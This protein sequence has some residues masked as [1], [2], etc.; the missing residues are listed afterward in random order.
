[1]KKSRVIPYI[2]ETLGGITPHALAY[3]QQLARRAGKKGARDSTKYGESRTS[4][5]AFIVHH[6]QRISVAAKLGDANAIWKNIN[7]RRQQML[8]SA[9]GHAVVGA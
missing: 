5:R 4:A 8:K 2:V 9:R 1:M 6:T 3:T 7:S